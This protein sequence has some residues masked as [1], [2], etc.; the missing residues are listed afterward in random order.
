MW[1][2]KKRERADELELAYV[3]RLQEIDESNQPAGTR[4]PT[5]ENLKRGQ[6]EY[7]GEITRSDCSGYLVLVAA[8]GM[9]TEDPG[10]TESQLWLSRRDLSAEIVEFNMMILRSS[11]GQKSLPDDAWDFYYKTLPQL[12]DVLEPMRVQWFPAIE[13]Y[14]FV[15][16]ANSSPDFGAD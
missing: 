7:L 6:T 2:K 12:L 16:E 15:N 1:A 8:M 9:L 4:G 5:I 11:E 10:R 13:A 3:R 14:K